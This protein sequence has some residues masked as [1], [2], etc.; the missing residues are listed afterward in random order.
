MKS[1]FSPS[2]QSRTTVNHKLLGLAP[3][4]SSRFAIG[5]SRLQRKQTEK[6]RPCC[7]PTGGRSGWWWQHSYE[8]KLEVLKNWLVLKDA[9]VWGRAVLT[10][11]ELELMCAY[12]CSLRAFV[13]TDMYNICIRWSS[14]KQICVYIYTHLLNRYSYKSDSDTNA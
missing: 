2:S 12:V 5:I 14:N 3:G 4:G 8:V 11:V 10:Q 9:E 1:D 13:Y 6:R 7:L